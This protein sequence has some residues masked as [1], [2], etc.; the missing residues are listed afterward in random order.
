MEKEFISEL[1]AAKLLKVN[2]QTMK[3]WR[4]KGKLDGIFIE[5]KYPTISRI[6]Y[7][8]SKLLEWVETFRC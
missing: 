1:Q 6:S 2:P 7:E 3:N 4:E 8:K 5:N